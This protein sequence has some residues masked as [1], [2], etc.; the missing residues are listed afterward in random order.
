MVREVFRVLG[1]FMVLG[2]GALV[3]FAQILPLEEGSVDSVVRPYYAVGAFG[4][5]S[6]L[7]NS[8]TND[9]SDRYYL[10][11]RIEQDVKDGVSRKLS[12]TNRM[13]GDFSAGIF[14]CHLADTMLRKADMGYWFSL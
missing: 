12:S 3:G 5:Y 11:K 9:F 10:G 4:N 2:M 14:Y 6:F 13:G 7:S 8:I 1:V